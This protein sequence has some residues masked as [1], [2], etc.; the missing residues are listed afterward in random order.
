MRKL[1]GFALAVVLAAGCKD[2]SSSS[3]GSSASSDQSSE[4]G[5]PK[6]RSGKVDFGPRRPVLPGEPEKKDEGSGSA[7]PQ[8]EKPSLADLDARRTAR[9]AQFDKDGDGVISEDERKAARH[10]RAEDMLKKADT[11]GDGKVTPDELAA[12]NFRRLDPQSLD[13]NKDGNVTAD[14]LEA[15][16]DARTKAWGAGRFGRFDRSGQTQKLGRGSGAGSGTPN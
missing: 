3:S 13:I 15:A 9:M 4:V 2:S 12:G 1:F 14:E 11:N 10:Q 7:E 5:K 8:R 16:L 6:G